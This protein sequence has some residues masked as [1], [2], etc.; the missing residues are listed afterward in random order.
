MFLTL[1]AQ[2]TKI[3]L[4]QPGLKLKSHEVMDISEELLSFE[5]N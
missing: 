3:S 1:Y 2:N 4:L 5:I